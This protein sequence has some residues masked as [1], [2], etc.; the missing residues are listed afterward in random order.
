VEDD[1]VSIEAEIPPE[2][3]VGLEARG[4][5][6]SIGSMLDFGAAQTI[7]R[8]EHGYIAASESRRDGCAVGF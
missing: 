2:T 1:E 5:K 3:L 4:H 7:L 6:L 8:V